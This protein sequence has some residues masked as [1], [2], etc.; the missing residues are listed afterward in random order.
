M[1]K[2]ARGAGGRPEPVKEKKPEKRK[3]KMAEKS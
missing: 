3:K 1:T 2:L